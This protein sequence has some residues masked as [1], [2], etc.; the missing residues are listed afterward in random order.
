MLYHFR[1]LKRRS[2]AVLTTV[3]FAAA[4][5]VAGAT[6]TAPRGTAAPSLAPM[7]AI[8]SW[9]TTHKPCPTDPTCG[10]GQMLWLRSDGQWVT[11]DGQVSP[12]LRTP[13]AP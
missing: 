11:S 9:P 8:R 3:L 12:S 7:P 1:H 6:L 4:S 2:L 10:D 5:V 13:P